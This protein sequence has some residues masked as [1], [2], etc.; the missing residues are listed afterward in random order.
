MTD[1]YSRKDDSFCHVFICLLLC[2]LLRSCSCRLLSPSDLSPSNNKGELK[3]N[4]PHVT[5]VDFPSIHETML[6]SRIS[7][8]IYDF[9][10]DLATCETI[11]PRLGP[12]FTCHYYERDEQDTEVMI[13]SH[14]VSQ[15]VAVVYRGTVD[16]QNF[17]TDVNISM[18]PFCIPKD[19]YTTDVR[20]N[21]VTKSATDTS[22]SC[23]D[24]PD[25]P[26][27]VHAGFYN[28]V[29]RDGLYHR[30]LKHVNNIKSKH[31]E[32]RIITTGHSLGAAA[33][34]LTAVAFHTS[35]L[36]PSN[37]TITSINFGCPQTGNREWYN[38]VNSLR[39][40]VDIW[41]YVHQH[42]VVTRL[43]AFDFWHVGHTLQMDSDMVRA[44][45]LHYGSSRNAGVPSGWNI[46]SL[47]SSPIGTYEHLLVHY[48]EYFQDKESEKN[49]TFVDMFEKVDHSLEVDS[50]NE[51]EILKFIRATASNSHLDFINH[52]IPFRNIFSDPQCERIANSSLESITDTDGWKD[53][54]NRMLGCYKHI[55][56]TER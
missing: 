52:Y 32:Y 18:K 28:S 24:N 35:S 33:S 3:L 6:L 26:V 34:V 44:Y 10:D 43:P 54:L 21:H 48:I 38:W 4:E 7:H 40:N 14:E 31:P 29:F 55:T 47:I 9:R 20:S 30:I 2:S 15:F 50:F 51:D 16:L 41:R 25:N 49:I 56:S 46:Y 45:Y 39:P 1:M 17:I 19:T 11:S 42:D 37:E 22:I 8:Q 12:E 27:H 23:T 53:V 13:V 36:F 5:D